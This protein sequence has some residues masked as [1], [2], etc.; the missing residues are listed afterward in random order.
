MFIKVSGKSPRFS[1]LA[2]SIETKEFDGLGLDALTMTLILGDLKE[3]LALE[4]TGY[5]TG[6]S[7]LSL[8]SYMLY[9][10]ESM[11]EKFLIIK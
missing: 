2:C 1:Y 8:S 3:S 11:F 10:G 5:S 4:C 9:L 7:S 6:N